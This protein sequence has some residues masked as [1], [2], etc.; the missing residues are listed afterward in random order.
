MIIGIDA[1]EIQNG[2]YT[3]IGRVVH[4]FLSYFSS[5]N[6]ENRII[7]F[8]EK[9][10]L[11]SYG[12][13]VQSEVI[14]PSFTSM[15][16]D[17]VILCR[18]IRKYSI[19]LFYSP[20]YKVPVFAGIPV[21][22]TVFDLMY[23]YYPFQWKG[24]SFF[25]RLY[26]RV[27]G[28]VMMNKAKWVFTCSHYSKSEI[29]RF[30]KTSE[31]KIKVIYLGLSEKYKPA[32]TDVN[33]QVLSRFAIHEPYLLYTGNFKPHKN[34]KILLDAF[35]KIKKKVPEVSLVLA[36]NKDQNFNDVEEHLSL[37]DCGLSVITTG[38]IAIEEQIAL[39]SKASVFVF[40]SLYEGFGYPPLEAMA[41]GA[42]VVSS[43]LTS[44]DEILGNAA[45]RCDPKNPDDI[46]QKVLTLL[47][48]QSLRLSCI[49]KGFENVKRF[50]NVQFCE[51]FYNLLLS[52]D[53]SR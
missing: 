16:W 10:L 25:S 44:L 30:Y 52:Q 35:T 49:S 13:R 5:L 33:G 19:D 42:P 38:K 15:Y 12:E 20:Y 9:V 21:V 4:V 29:V 27:A 45:L 3:G 11:H 31:T 32:A 50:L 39:Y 36:G 34:V 6:D 37:L 47:S 22:N 51:E 24:N 28:G 26:Y 43:G 48:D 14:P 17:Q 23:I 46:A 18:C 40:P 7:L 1:R 8:S 2:V 53:C 41:C